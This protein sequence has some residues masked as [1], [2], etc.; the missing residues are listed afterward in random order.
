MVSVPLRGLYFFIINDN[1]QYAVGG[2]SMF[3][4]PY[5]DYIFLLVNLLANNRLC[6][7]GF[8]PLTGI[9][10]FYKLGAL[11]SG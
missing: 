6:P 2:Y 4:S 7:Q 10:F 8:R 3:P 1:Q 11:M 5:G 9:I